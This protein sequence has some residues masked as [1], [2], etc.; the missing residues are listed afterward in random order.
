MRTTAISAAVE[1]R[2]AFDRLARCGQDVAA[3]LFERRPPPA[4]GDFVRADT[5]STSSA[6]KVSATCASL[7]PYRCQSTW[8]WSTG[9]SRR[10]SATRWTSSYPVDGVSRRSCA[11]AAR[12]RQSAGAPAPATPLG[13][14]APADRLRRTVDR[15]PRNG[16]ARGPASVDQR[17]A[18]TAARRRAPRPR[19][20]SPASLERRQ[21]TSAS[22]HP[23][24]PAARCRP[25]ENAVHRHAACRDDRRDTAATACHRLERC[26]T[27]ESRRDCP[28]TRSG[29]ERI[30]DE[31]RRRR[32][33]RSPSPRAGAGEPRRPPC[34]GSADRAIERTASR[35][36]RQWLAG[37]QALQQRFN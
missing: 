20:S 32:A 9:T 5:P 7:G 25:S 14:A 11:A 2:V 36:R 13:R 37:K 18:A 12:R 19:R 6:P 10:A 26:P 24:P 1:Q 29:R 28:P 15:Q 4:F 34:R 31:R 3:D 16:Q 33:R 27:I 23:C 21:H 30:V 35:R 8:M 22:W 17:L